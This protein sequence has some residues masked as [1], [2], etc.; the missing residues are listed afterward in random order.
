M[1]TVCLLHVSATLVAIL[2]EVHYKG[3]IT[4]LFGP[5]H[6]YKI[7]SFDMCGLICVYI[8][9]QNTDKIFCGKFYVRHRPEM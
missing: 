3:Y 8:K 6:K 4:Q 5:M 2:R 7:L 1:Y 9:T